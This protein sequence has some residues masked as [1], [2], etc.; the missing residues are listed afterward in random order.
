[1][2]KLII[3]KNN[4]QFI[5]GTVKETNDTAII[6]TE[7]YLVN[8]G[9]DGNLNLIPYFVAYPIYKENKEKEKAID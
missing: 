9:Q 5:I 8:A 6:L 1:M 3:E 2:V 7:P 4:G